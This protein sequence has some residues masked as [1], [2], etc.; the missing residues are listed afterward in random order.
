MSLAL[1]LRNASRGPFAA[2][3]QRRHVRSHCGPE[4]VVVSNGPNKP[5][6][7]QL[8]L[9][10]PVLFVIASTR[11]VATSPTVAS[12]SGPADGVFELPGGGNFVLGTLYT[13]DGQEPVYTLHSGLV[14]ILSRSYL[15]VG[16]MNGTL[17]DGLGDGPDFQVEGYYVAAILFGAGVGYFAGEMYDSSGAEAGYMFG[18]FLDPQVQ[19]SSPLGLFEG[20][21]EFEP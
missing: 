6:S 3:M 5:H 14:P 9:L 2:V 15:Q 18:F 13:A 17:D 16:G 19:G 21:Y 7:M 4:S 10:V 12:T 1:S 8:S 20:E 11:P